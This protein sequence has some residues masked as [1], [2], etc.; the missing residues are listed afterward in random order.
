M[1]TL[2]PMATG[3]LVVGINKATKKFDE[4]L[5]CDKIYYA[6]YE[7]GLETDTLDSEGSVVNQ[8]NVVISED[9]F[10]KVLKN[11]VGKTSQLPPIYSAK[12]INGKKAY[13]LARQ[14]VEFELKPKEVE[15]FDLKFIRSNGKNS[16]TVKIHCSSGFYVRCLGRDIAKTFG[17]F[18][19]TTCI[20]RVQCSNFNIENANKFEDIEENKLN[21]VSL[22]TN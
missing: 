21:F 12:K 7:F 10:K 3:L 8:N 17:T 1:G 14:G 15:L 20:R 22:E 11:F 13:E 19:T 2:D 6:T 5:K 16:F 9:D 4:F 18:A